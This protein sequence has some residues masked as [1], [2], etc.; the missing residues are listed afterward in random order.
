LP[1]QVVILDSHPQQLLDGFWAAAV[2]GGG[3]DALEAPWSATSAGT[4]FI[5]NLDESSK[6]IK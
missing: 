3:K 2:A 1:G 5:T 4:Y 6:H